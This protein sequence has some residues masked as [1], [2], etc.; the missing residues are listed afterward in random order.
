MKLRYGYNINGDYMNIVICDDNPIICEDISN[1]INN[2]FK[3]TVSI[4]ANSAQL[5][6]IIE[7]SENKID[8]LIL[9]IVLN[10]S[11]NGIEIASSIHNKYPMIKVIFLTGYDDQ[12]YSRIFSDFQ[13]FG[14]VAKPVQYNILNFFLKKIQIELIRK[15]EHIEF[16]SDYKSHRLMAK[17]IVCVQSRKRICEIST[18]T[19]VYSAYAKISDI[20]KQLPENFIRC[21]QS[22]IVNIEYIESTTGKH[23]ILKNGD[24]IPVSRK[25][26]NN[27]STLLSL[28][29]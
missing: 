21:H 9:D 11:K 8:A 29:S 23:L 17:D 25:Y 5:F 4:A 24:H 3:C 14:F 26:S 20:E 15:N 13:P 16:T 28:S 1:Y 12:Y 18:E 10:E 6:D 22:Y 7:N 27:V 19:N 2:H